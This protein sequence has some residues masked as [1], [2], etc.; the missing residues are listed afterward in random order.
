MRLFLSR[1]SS[2]RLTNESLYSCLYSKVEKMCLPE[3]GSASQQGKQ[4]ISLYVSTN[5]DEEYAIRRHIN[6]QNAPTVT[7][8]H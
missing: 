2:S 3:D 8:H 1:Y 5:G 6:V 4:V 7:L